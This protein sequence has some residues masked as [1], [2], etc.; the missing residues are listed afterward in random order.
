MLLG[1]RVGVASDFTRS[2]IRRPLS[3]RGT[4]QFVFVISVCVSSLVQTERP[5][6]LT[7][8]TLM[9]FHICFAMY[10]YFSLR[11]SFF[12]DLIYNSLMCSIQSYT[13]P[14]LNEFSNTS[15]VFLWGLDPPSRTQSPRAKNSGTFPLSSVI[16]RFYEKMLKE[17]SA[18]GVVVFRIQSGRVHVQWRGC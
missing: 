6:Y 1:N 8:H 9:Y 10:L 15:E 18:S 16:K 4:D 2:T 12:Q 13:C 14:S 17:D 5:L 11:S 3:A 7:K